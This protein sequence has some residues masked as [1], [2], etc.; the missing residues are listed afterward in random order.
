MP[1]IYRLH[2][3]ALFGDFGQVILGVVALVWTLDTFNGVYLTL[4]T[5]LA[6]FWRRWRTAWRVKRGGSTF[7]LNF[8]L[9]RAGGLWFAV[10]LFIFAWSSV[11]MNIRP[12]YELV[13]RALF[14]YESQMAPY[15]RG[16]HPNSHPRLGWREAEAAGLRLMSEQAHLKGFKAGQ[17]LSLMYLPEYGAYAYDVRG[18]RDLFERAPKGGSTTVLF[19]GDTGTFR[20]LSQPTGEHLGNTIES[21]LYALHM[22]RIF[23]RPYQLLVCLTGLVTA[24]LS[25]TGIYIFVRKRTARSS[26][27]PT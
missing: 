2:W 6:N 20:A 9:H 27:R 18:S 8:D 17:A 24:L 25:A 21:W 5:T 13:M 7:R 4:P 23:G 10:L 26:R 11:M 15:E 16:A 14:D 3:T 19:D 22:A 1:F 12:T